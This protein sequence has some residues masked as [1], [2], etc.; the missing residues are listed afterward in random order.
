M[1]N[2]VDRAFAGGIM[3]FERCVPFMEIFTLAVSVLLLSSGA[4]LTV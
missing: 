1:V 3:F 2:M 4:Y